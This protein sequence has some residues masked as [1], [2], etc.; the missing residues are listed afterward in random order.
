MSIFSHDS[1]RSFLQ[2]ELAERMQR[3]PKYSLRAMARALGLASS[4]LSEV[5]NGRANFSTSTAHRVA[6]A[7]NLKD[8]ETTY[9]CDLVQLESTRDPETRQMLTD[10]LRRNYPK[11]RVASNLALDQ[12]EQMSNWYH[13]AMLELPHLR[14]FKFTAENVAKTLG[15]TKPSAQLAIER[16]KRLDL[17]E[18]EPSGVA[19]R[20]SPH[21]KVSSPVKHQA[22]R[23]YYRQM[24]AKIETALSEQTPQERLSGY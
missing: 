16:L 22:M 10:R 23:K 6:L 15:I 20:K 12:F 24:L 18:V 9:L 19:R 11:H 14:G 4:T 7:L 1:Y 3:N 17:I 5:I 8:Q 13:M 21:L 2:A